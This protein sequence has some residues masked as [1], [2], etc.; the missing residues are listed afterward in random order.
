MRAYRSQRLL[1]LDPNPIA[2]AYSGRA[3]SERSKPLVGAAQRASS[4]Q[5]TRELRRVPAAAAGSR[6]DRLVGKREFMAGSP[7]G[8]DIIDDD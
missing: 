8:L 6:P 3:G 5:R 1:D 4:I 2:A 7:L